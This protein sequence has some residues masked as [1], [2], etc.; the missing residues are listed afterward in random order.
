MLGPGQKQNIFDQTERKYFGPGRTGI[1]PKITQRQFNYIHL[2][3]SAYATN[4]KETYDNLKL[5]LDKIL[6]LNFYSFA[7]L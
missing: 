2:F 7:Y 3:S 6:N 5:V 4:T 1:V